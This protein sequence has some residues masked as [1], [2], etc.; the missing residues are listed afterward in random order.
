MTLDAADG[1]RG[2][3]PRLSSVGA[4]NQNLLKPNLMQKNRTNA[5]TSRARHVSGAFTLI[6]LLVVIAI[7]AILAAMLLPALSKAKSKALRI[8][9]LNNLKQLG[10]GSVLYAQDFNGHLTAPTWWQASFTP[11]AN[12]DRSGSD[13]DATW[14]YPTYVRVLGSY[15]CPST[16][17]SIRTDP[18]H[19]QKKPFSTDTYLTD[20]VDNAVNKKANGTSYEIFG[21][22]GN[23]NAAGGND[24]IKKTDRSVNSR[25]L[26]IYTSAIGYKPGPSGILLFLDADDTGSEGLGSTHNNW[27]DPQDNH[28]ADGTCMNFCDGHA[29]YIRRVE[30]LKVLNSSQDGNQKEP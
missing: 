30:Y 21:T 10:L 22:I 28:G 4:Q 23:K 9:C 26:S 2:T 20:L 29:Q 3:D 7:I 6:E 14:L 11:T 5:A 19:V 12:T 18:D 16:Q 27:P 13:D 1:R 25:P 8:S 24:P 17:N 15:V